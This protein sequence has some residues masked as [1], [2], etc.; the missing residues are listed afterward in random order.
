MLDPAVLWNMV[1]KAEK[2]STA[3]VARDFRI[4][5]PLGLGKD[6]AIEMARGMARFIIARFNTPV[7]IGVHR[8]NTI[9]LDGNNKD[10]S[11]VGFHAHLYFPT[12]ELGKEGEGDAARWFLDRK[13]TA[14]SN[15]S[16]SGELVDLLNAKWAALASRYAAKA[17][18]SV[19]LG[20]GA[21]A[22]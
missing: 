22:T 21:S 10:E 19:W 4:P 2:Q 20:S 13:L 11:K 8:D 9:D 18:P 7:S 12:R 6:D 17:P 16:T 5:I 3:Q 15:R 1:D 14:L